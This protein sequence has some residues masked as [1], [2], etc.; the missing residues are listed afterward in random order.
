MSSSEFVNI[1]DHAASIVRIK[2]SSLK[3]VDDVLSAI[4]SRISADVT[5]PRIN[6]DLFFEPWID[7]QQLGVPSETAEEV[8][9]ELHQLSVLR[10]WTRLRCPDVGSDE[11]GTVIETDS[12]RVLLESL[13]AQC[14]QCGSHHELVPTL[15]ETVYAP[16]FPNSQPILAFDAA[17][18][19]LE[20]PSLK[21]TS[22]SQGTQI[23]RT[24]AIANVAPEAVDSFLSLLSLALSK[25]AAVQAVPT[26]VEVWL[27]AWKGPAAILLAYMI[28]IGPVAWCAGQAIAILM[29]V[30]ILVVVWMFL[31][32]EVQA[33]LAPS[34]VQRHTTRLGLCL[35]I[36]LV[37][38]G[39]TGIEVSF[40]DENKLTIPIWHNKHVVLPIKIEYGTT[41]LW[42]VGAGVF[43]FVSTLVFVYLYDR[44][45]GWL[46]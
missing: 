25:N 33:K 2:L 24:A 43:C 4:R 30:V 19:H 14:P 40:K 13:D 6:R 39:T 45:K 7:S 22:L 12:E 10:L 42:L 34:A 27:G 23:E 21:G 8:S 41:N 46:A 11:D 29:S 5:D 28:L 20:R 32:S 18:L 37:A 17:R 16:N 31:K 1:F 15:V 38:A 35:A 26:T 9:R 44:Q 3:G 36:V